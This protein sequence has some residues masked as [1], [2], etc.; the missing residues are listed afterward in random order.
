MLAKPV[1]VPAQKAVWLASCATD[2]KTGLLV[3]LFSPWTMLVGA[4]KEGWRA[5]LKRPEPPL[6]LRIRVIPIDQ[7][8]TNAV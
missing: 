2:G 1:E 3:S 7:D 4:L 8:E 5:L 6:D